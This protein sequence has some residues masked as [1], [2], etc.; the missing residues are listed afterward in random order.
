MTGANMLLAAVLRKIFINVILKKI[1]SRAAP[2]KSYITVE[3]Y[4]L[5]K[6]GRH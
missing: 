5:L 1:A 4:L 2:A 3:S 6:G